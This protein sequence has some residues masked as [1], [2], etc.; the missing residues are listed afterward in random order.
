MLHMDRVGVR[1]LRLNASRLLSRVERGESV[2][3]T[4]RGR[5]VARIVPIRPA[6]GLAQLL[7]EGA[8]TAPEEPGDLLDVPAVEPVP[9]APLPSEVL[10]DMRADER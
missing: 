8:A 1:E 5:L 3:V 7:A 6:G 10:A 4:S 2:E 9:G